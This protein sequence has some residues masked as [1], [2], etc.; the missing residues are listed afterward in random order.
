[1]MDDLLRDYT[2]F[3]YY[4]KRVT[5]AVCVASALAAPQAA[6]LVFIG[7]VPEWHCA[8]SAASS[9]NAVAA[10]QGLGNHSAHWQ[11]NNIPGVS[12]SSPTQCQQL[13]SGSCSPVYKHRLA[14]ASSEFGL[15]CSHATDSSYAQ[16]LYFVGMLL[17]SW[18]A[19][20]SSD[21][22][23]RRAAILVAMVFFSLG[24]L[25]TM[26]SGSFGSF[27]I[28]RLVT[29]IGVMGLCV[30]SNVLV[31]ESVA[32][33]HRALTTTSCNL[34]SS[35]GLAGLSLLASYNSAS[36]RRLMGILTVLAFSASLVVY[37]WV[38][39]S[40]FWLLA[41]KRHDQLSVMLQRWASRS[42]KSI[43]DRLLENLSSSE[44]KLV[45]SDDEIHQSPSHHSTVHLSSL[46]VLPAFRWH[47]L[48]VLWS[49]FAVCMMYF[50]LTLHVE[51]VGSNKYISFFFVAIVELP[52]LLIAIVVLKYIGRRTFIFWTMVM[53]T[54]FCTLSS[55]IAKWS[56][57]VNGNDSTHMKETIANWQLAV[58]ICGKFSSSA[59]F[60][61]LYTYLPEL[62]PT[63]V[64]TSGLGVCVVVSR[65]GAIISPFVLAW[66]HRHPMAPYLL[67]SVCGAI[68]CAGIY[69]LPETKDRD[70]PETL[71]D[72]HQLVTKG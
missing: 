24:S 72:L 69:R 66:G 25:W 48:S 32:P 70:L 47:T 6:I 53:T 45:G 7:S 23:G 43:P 2:P 11:H 28:S 71:Q 29:G 65:L 35:I 18:L 21:A 36:W 34:F 15:I 20:W 17:G 14:S 63:P 61:I 68:A 51:G 33:E 59:V 27:A 46:L 5:L 9:S 58:S 38:S 62:L 40:P 64:R 16:S 4:Q 12:D 26:L 3:S 30:T 8:G 54:V 67:F 37:I 60:S 57:Q 42:G 52:A 10:A 31:S 13:A 49:W 41:S 56:T 19:G 1:M 55:F 39:E 22:Y 50:G 44:E